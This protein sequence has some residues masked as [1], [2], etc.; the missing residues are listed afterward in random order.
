MLPCLHV[1]I[2][3]WLLSRS[4]FDSRAALWGEASCGEEFLPEDLFKTRQRR[5]TLHDLTVPLPAESLKR[6]FP[7]KIVAHKILIFTPSHP[8]PP[9]HLRNFLSLETFRISPPVY[10]SS[11]QDRAVGVSDKPYMKRPLN[12]STR[13]GLDAAWCVVTDAGSQTI[14][15]LLR[16]AFSASESERGWSLSGSLEKKKK[17]TPAGCTHPRRC[18][19]CVARKYP[20]LK[21]YISLLTLM[22]GGSISPNGVRQHVWQAESLTIENGL[23]KCKS[24]IFFIQILLCYT[25]IYLYL[26]RGNKRVCA[27]QGQ[28]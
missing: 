9:N 19:S 21:L 22:A 6:S 13:C 3:L 17:K 18:H 4:C 14:L 24:N 11:P 26:Y 23:R 15:P 12:P 25:H 20:N 27:E 16:S 8:T 7:P 10:E 5:T 28:F 2:P 1:H